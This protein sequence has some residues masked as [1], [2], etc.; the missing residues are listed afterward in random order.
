VNDVASEQ[1]LQR[2]REEIKRIASDILKRMKDPRLGF[3]TVTDV[4]VSKDLR[5]VWIYVSVLGE[6]ES[7]E[8]TVTA[9][10]SG[11]GHFRSELGSRISLRHTPS[12]TFRLD[13]SA[14][15]G[16]RIEALL[17]ELHSEEPEPHA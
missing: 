7:V 15:K 2:L 11:V 14:E 16:A 3:V 1:R 12:V 5:Y 17:A 4:E 6:A 9:L 13:R 8:E 10:K